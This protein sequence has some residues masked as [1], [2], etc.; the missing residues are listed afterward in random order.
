M[1]GAFISSEFKVKIP[2]DLNDKSKHEREKITRMFNILHLLAL[3]ENFIII[4]CKSLRE[5]LHFI[6]YLQ[7]EV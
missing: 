4:F 3:T 6:T 2:I 7:L 5:H 1:P